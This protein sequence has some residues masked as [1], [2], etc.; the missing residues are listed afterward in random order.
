MKKKIVGIV[1]C[2]LLIGTT[3]PVSGNVL[4]ESTSMP[5]LS[6]LTL[7]VGGS[8]PNNYTSIQEAIDDASNGDTV[9]VYDDSSPYYENLV[10]EKSIYLIG[11]AKETTVIDAN[12]KEDADVILIKSDEVTIQGFTIQNTASGVYPDYDNG[13]EIELQ[14]TEQWFKDREGKFTGSEFYKLMGTTRTTSKMEWGRAEKRIDFNKTALKY[15]YNK[16][17]E[18][19]TGKVIRQHIGKNG[20]YGTKMEKHVI[21]IFLEQNKH[22][23]YQA[24]NFIEFIKGIAGASP[25]GKLIDTI[26]KNEF[27]LEIKCPVSWDAEFERQEQVTVQHQD[28]WQIQGEMLALKVKNLIYIVGE[29][30]KD[31][32]RMPTI[33]SIKWQIVAASQIH[34][35][36]LIHRCKIGDLAMNYFLQNNDIYKSIELAIKNYIIKNER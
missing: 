8:G 22:Y 9:F 15:I 16:A 33:D 29:P 13:I 32:L 17:R 35:Q 7:Y 34:Q 14:R 4:L 10:I 30:T 27:G 24:C 25:D 5:L 2:M 11:E 31:I 6:G 36:E 12:E 20:E 28:F 19:Q 26:T 21:E 18:R 3:L 1:V 23:E